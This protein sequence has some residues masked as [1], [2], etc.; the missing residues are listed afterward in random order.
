MFE[1]KAEINATV[2]SVECLIGARVESGDTLLILES[3]KMEIPVVSPVSGVVADVRVSPS[4]SVSQG[5][6]LVTIEVNSGPTP[7]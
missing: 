7:S 5:L 2:W 1:L 6:V 4:E 3:M